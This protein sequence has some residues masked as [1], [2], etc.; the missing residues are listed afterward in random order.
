MPQMTNTAGGL[1][2]LNLK[3]A[4]NQ[5]KINLKL[6][7]IY[8]IVKKKQTNELRKGRLNYE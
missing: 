4:Q 8:N 1:K 6:F 7:M 2:K 3:N 5:V